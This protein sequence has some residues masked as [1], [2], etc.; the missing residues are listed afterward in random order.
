VWPRVHLGY[1]AG[2]QKET[3]VVLHELFACLLVERA[4][5]EGHDQEALDDLE[6][7]AETPLLHVPVFLEGGHADVPRRAHVRVEDLGQ[8]VA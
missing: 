7:I 3:I 6:D 4:L 1:Q 2:L 5:R 8:E